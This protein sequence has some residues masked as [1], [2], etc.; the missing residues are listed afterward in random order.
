MNNRRPPR[1]A[2]PGSGKTN[3][4][5]RRSA[6]QRGTGNT[7]SNS[8]HDDRKPKWKSSGVKPLKRFGEDGRLR[9]GTVRADAPD[10]FGAKPAARKGKA[11]PRLAPSIKITSDL[12][13]TDGRFAGLLLGNSASPRA[14]AMPREARDL[15]FRIIARRTRGSR[16]LDLCAGCGTVGLEAVSRGSMLT[17]FIERSARAAYFLRCNIERIGIKTGHAEV[18][19][20]EA[21]PYLKRCAVRKRTWDIVF[22]C[23][24]GVAVDGEIL[25]LVA[26]GRVIEPGGIA[27]IEHA[28]DHE[29]P[30]TLGALTQWRTLTKDNLSLSF[31]NRK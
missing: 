13:I 21:A 28:T 30:Q 11:A 6:D 18:V 3:E 25:E 2:S 5:G 7:R 27:V 22:L 4:R 23:R 24:T 17:T 26:A 19:E 16:F 8:A 1:S 14:A 29:L 9:A 20:I 31:Y 15:M 10:R 12:Q